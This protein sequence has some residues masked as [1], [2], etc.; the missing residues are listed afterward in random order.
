MERQKVLNLFS[1]FGQLVRADLIKCWKIFH[2]EVDPGLLDGFTV[3]VDR[4]TR[5][6]SFKIVVP[7]CVLEIRS[8]I[9]V[10]VIQWWYSLS[11]LAVTQPALSYFKRELK[12]LDDLLYTVL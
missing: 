10:W 12:E 1:S 2:S 8:F 5:G 3:A 4:R 11:E 9:H 7:S 6:H